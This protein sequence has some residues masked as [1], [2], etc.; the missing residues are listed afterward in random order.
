M[1]CSGSVVPVTGH[2][3]VRSLL[4]Y[5]DLT[6]DLPVHGGTIVMQCSDAVGAYVRGL[7]VDGARWDQ[8]TRRLSESLPKVL[9]DPMP[10]VSIG[11]L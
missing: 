8:N 5:G 4:W 9:Y 6:G 1:N 7:Y 11:L 10:V 3:T 2:R